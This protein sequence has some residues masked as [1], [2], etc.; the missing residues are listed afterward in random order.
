MP[1]ATGIR[2]TRRITHYADKFGRHDFKFGAEFER[3]KT[4]DRYGYNDGLTFYD[5]GGVPYYAYS[6][7]YDLSGKNT[8]TSLFAQD[9]WRIGSRLTREPRRARRPASGAST[10]TVGN[11]YSSNNWAPRLGVAFDVLGDNR[12]VAKATYGQYYE[13]AQTA[14]FTRAVPGIQDFI[15]YY[16]HRRNTHDLD[17]VSRTASVGPLQNGRQHQ[18][19][20]RRRGDARLRA[21]D[22]RRDAARRHRH[23][24]R[25]QELRQLGQSASRAGGGPR[26][27]PDQPADP[28]VS[29]GP[30]APPP[31]SGATSSSRTST[32]SSTTTR[33]A[34]SSARAHPF[35]KYRAF[36]AGPVEA[37][38]QPLAGPGV[39]RLFEDDGQRRQLG[40]SASRDPAVHD[41]QLR[42]G[43]RRRASAERSAARVQAARARTRFRGSKCR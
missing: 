38:R 26:P 16:V 11:V 28:V 32:G 30:T 7:G 23:L 12:T 39:V 41:A 4:R 22:Y 20:A 1:T 10:P 25:Q 2:S 37:V 18:A 5:Y 42:V 17:E 14:L 43:Q 3:S 6:Y 34:A 21:G 36:M 24:A 8:R 27:R 40:R 33:T 13:G 31:T 9:S 19:P 35:R 15:T 29:A